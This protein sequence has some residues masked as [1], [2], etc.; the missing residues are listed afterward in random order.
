MSTPRIVV[1]DGFTLNPGDLSWAPLAAL[2]RLM[3]FERS[4]PRELL[5]RAAGAELLITN[6]AVIDRAAIEALPELR[7]IGVTAT[8]TNIV[9]RDAARSRGVVVSNVPSYGADSVAE[10]ALS[11][12]LEGVKHLSQHLGAVRAGGWSKQPDFSFTVAPVSLLAGKTLGLVGL[13]AIGGRVAEL[14]LAFRMTVL[15]AR[16][17]GERAADASSSTSGATPPGVE[18]VPLDELLGRADI[19]SLHCPL[20]KENERFV[21]ARRLAQMKPTAL[22]INTSRGGLI[23]EAA[24]AAA[25]ERRQIA[26]AYL[27]VLSL[28]PPPEG[29]PL[30]GLPHCWITPHMAWASVEARRRLLDVSIANVCAFLAGHPVNVVT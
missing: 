24:L 3:V 7:Y 23:D 6:K 12:M 18:R 4:T 5:S 27:D 19:L 2:G 25:L 15:A 13:G 21:D 14:G 28:E 11:L 22:L 10:H 9:D 16:R 17:E 8:G 1:L 29:H 26:G 20:T 30:L